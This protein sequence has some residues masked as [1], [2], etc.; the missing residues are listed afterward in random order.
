VTEHQNWRELKKA[1][2]R[3][4]IQEHAL[5]LF[6]EQGYDAT[7]VKQIAAAAGVSHMTFFRYF[8]TK[9]DVV[10]SDDYDP[11]LEQLIT[12]RP[13]DESVVDSIQ[14][15]ISE[16]FGLVYAADRATILERVNLLMSAPALQARLWENQLST[17]QM[18]E[19]ALEGRGADPFEVRVLAGACLAAL[20]A[21][22]V[23]WSESPDTTEL[24]ALIDDSFTILRRR[25][26]TE[27]VAARA[28]EVRRDG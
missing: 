2:T 20:T 10:L 9:E 14:A 28:G 22:I 1:Q 19:R 4:S 11:L 3:R 27:P 17:Q 25:L 18:F 12:A 26:P 7:T 5:R 8:P 15:A 6:A 16:A 13:A 23:A 24:P 21:A